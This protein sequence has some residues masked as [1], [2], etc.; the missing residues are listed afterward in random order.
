M[1]FNFK[2]KIRLKETL[3]IVFLLIYFRLVSLTLHAVFRLTNSEPLGGAESYTIIIITLQGV[4]CSLSLSLSL[5][6]S[7][8]VCVCEC[9]TGKDHLKC[10]CARVRLFYFP[11]HL[12]DWSYNYSSFL[13]PY[14]SSA[15]AHTHTHTH[16][17]T[18]TQLLIHH[19]HKLK[20]SVS[21]QRTALKAT[22]QAVHLTQRSLVVDQR[23]K[24]FCREIL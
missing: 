11:S 2:S 9:W 17:R 5:S 8:Y 19:K 7:E 15:R 23:W 12:F 3:D 14:H 16:T 6:L 21:L 24:L 22:S 10:V 18:R 20:I 1:D 4:F 13:I